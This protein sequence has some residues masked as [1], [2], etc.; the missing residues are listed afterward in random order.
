MKDLIIVG[1][2]GVGIEA[3][4]VAEA[5][6][7]A[8]PADQPSWRIVGFCDDNPGRCGE[9]VQGWRVL[10]TS[11]QVADQLGGGSAGC[12]FH[13]AVG[14]NKH[15]RRLAEFFEARGF[16][17]ATLIHPS[18]VVAASA[19]IGAGSYIG[20]LTVV[21]PLAKVGRH[22]LINTSV[23]IGHH[24]VI[25]DFAQIC[26]GARINGGCRIDTGAFIGSNASVHPGLS[27]GEGAIVGANSF[28]VRSVKPHFSMLGVPARIVSRPAEGG[29]DAQK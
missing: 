18:A 6:N 20:P 26:P 15:R 14:Q 13:C 5:M 23:S 3:L 21:P 2:G 7:R 24:S 1:A 10:G 19:E 11:Q 9:E 12:H 8:R 22:V 25:G 16:I 29:P 28:V 27:I 17:P 4:W